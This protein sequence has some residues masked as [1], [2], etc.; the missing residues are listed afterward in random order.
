[1]G[2]GAP[3]V[4]PVLLVLSNVASVLLVG[5]GAG[6]GAAGAALGAGVAAGAAAGEATGT[7]AGD[8]EGAGT[9]TGDAAGEGGGELTAGAPLPRSDAVR[10]TAAAARRKGRCHTL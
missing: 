1:M 2:A 5:G 3:D 10:L 6:A 4:P 8:G 9:T 7:T